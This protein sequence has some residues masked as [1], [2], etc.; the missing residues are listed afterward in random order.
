MKNQNVEGTLKR[1][2][3]QRTGKIKTNAA[4][5]QGLVYLGI[6]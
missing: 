3:N 5:G 2:R 6:L 1:G 4:Q